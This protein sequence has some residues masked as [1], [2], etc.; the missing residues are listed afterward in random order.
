MEARAYL[1]PIVE[2]LRKQGVDADRHVMVARS[3]EEAVRREVESEGCDLIALATH[4]RGGIQRML[5]GSVATTLLQKGTT[6]L[7]I[8]NPRLATHD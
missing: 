6:P 5:L 8:V 4:G 3:V 7:L 1:D 2:S